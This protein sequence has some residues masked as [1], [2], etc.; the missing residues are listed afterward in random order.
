MGLIF[1]IFYI[2]VTLLTCKDGEDAVP[3][4]GDRESD[5]DPFAGIAVSL[6]VLVHI[7][8]TTN[9]KYIIREKSE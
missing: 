2:Q 8:A 4:G 5:P 9:M 1:A 7:P 6:R 3:K